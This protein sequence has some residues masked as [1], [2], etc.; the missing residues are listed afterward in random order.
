MPRCPLRLP[1]LG[2]CGSIPCLCAAAGC[3][4]RCRRASSRGDQGNA[5]EKYQTSS[6]LSRRGAQGDRCPPQSIRGHP[7]TQGAGTIAINLVLL[8]KVNSF[9]FAHKMLKHILR[10]IA[11]VKAVRQLV[12]SVC[13]HFGH[14]LLPLFPC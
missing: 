6:A 9:M 4:S 13:I 14:V 8:T 10:T 11:R 1:C 3:E 7:H 2:A 12:R 5:R